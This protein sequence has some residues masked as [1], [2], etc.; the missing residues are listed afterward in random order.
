MS[1]KKIK[2]SAS[3]TFKKILTYFLKG[4]LVTLP[5]IITFKLVSGIIEWIDS[6]LLLDIPG[7]GFGIVL[8]S[9]TIIGWGGSNIITKPFLNLMDD[10]FSKLPF[11]KII[12]TS[13]KELMEAFVGEKKKFTKPVVVEFT[14]GIFKPGFITQDDLIEINQPGIVGVYFPHSYAFSGN[15]FFVDKSKI[16]PYD[17]NSTEFMKFIV[18]GGVITID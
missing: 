12:Y 7:L 10:F 2:N 15:L 18:S 16:K 3:Q 13:V 11:I 9:V 14:V 6:L 1:N 5:L 8:I 4:L 17:G